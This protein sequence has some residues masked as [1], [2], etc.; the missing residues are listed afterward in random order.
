[1][2]VFVTEAN[3]TAL[4]SRLAGRDVVAILPIGFGKSLIQKYQP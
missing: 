2:E 4:E 3:R 1:M